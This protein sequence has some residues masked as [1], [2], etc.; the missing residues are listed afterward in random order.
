LADAAVSVV[1]SIAEGFERGGDREF[2]Q[3]LVLAK[4]SCGEVRAQLYI[5]LDQGYL[6]QDKFDH[7]SGLAI[8]IGRMLGGLMSYLKTSDYLGSK[9]K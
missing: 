8:Q 6:D 9:Y 1:S 4:G 3:F 7:L 5:A 2:R